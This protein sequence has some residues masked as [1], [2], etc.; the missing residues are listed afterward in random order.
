MRPWFELAVA[1]LLCW[2]GYRV[3]RAAL[4]LRAE[5]QHSSRTLAVGLA[6]PGVELGSLAGVDLGGKI[7]LQGPGKFR[8]FV[9]F[10]V[11]PATAQADLTLWR[12]VA[13]DLASA[14]GLKFEGPGALR[15]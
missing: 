10:V 5:A 1:V 6:Q 9:A 11:R 3:A 4:S 14:T 13:G 15:V 12:V 8:R 2:G 7:V